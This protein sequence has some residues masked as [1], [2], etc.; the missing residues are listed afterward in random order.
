[1]QAVFDPFA[2][3]GFKSA[4]E[5]G[6]HAFK[7]DAGAAITFGG[8]AEHQHITD[9]LREILIRPGIRHLEIA[10]ELP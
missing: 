7:L 5:I 8:G 1:M 4:L 10:G 9:Y 2:L 3:G 6:D